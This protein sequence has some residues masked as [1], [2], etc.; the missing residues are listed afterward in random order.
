MYAEGVQHIARLCRALVPEEA[1]PQ[2]ARARPRVASEQ[3]PS[4]A[5]SEAGRQ[6]S[7]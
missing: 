2:A 5:M 1:E 3:A 4:P 6:G 7:K